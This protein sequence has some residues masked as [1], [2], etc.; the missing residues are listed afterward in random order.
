MSENTLYSKKIK[1]SKVVI[2]LWVIAIGLLIL[3][4][5]L[6]AS[7][8]SKYKEGQKLAVNL[9]LE[10]TDRFDEYKND[11]K[12]MVAKM[13]DYYNPYYN[14]GLFKKGSLESEIADKQRKTARAAD[15]ALGELLDKAGYPAYNGSYYLKYIDFIDYSIHGRYIELSAVCGGFIILAILMSIFYTINKRHKMIVEAD[16]IICKNGSKTVKEFFIKDIKA[17][18]SAAF[19]SLV[20]RGNGFKYSINLI[21][22]VDELKVAIMKL[23]ENY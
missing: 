9:T 10:T 8:F 7:R 17:V 21:S 4:T 20:I 16:R 2:I 11:Y 6:S 13:Y 22:N 15:E 18:E 14:P 23:L 5:V 19:K 3:L 1:L 12:K